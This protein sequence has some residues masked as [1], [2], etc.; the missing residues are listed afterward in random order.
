M[1]VT[2]ESFALY[3]KTIRRCIHCINEYITTLSVPVSTSIYDQSGKMRVS[4]ARVISHVVMHGC[5]GCPNNVLPETTYSYYDPSFEYTIDEIVR[6]REEF[7]QEK[8]PCMSGIHGFLELCDAKRY[9]L[10]A[11]FDRNIW[12]DKYSDVLAQHLDR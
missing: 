12:I 1:R 10:D 3:K 9:D 2:S 4:R 7:S 5:N 8:L 11:I 6:P